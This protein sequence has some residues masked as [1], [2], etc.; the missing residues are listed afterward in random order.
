MLNLDAEVRDSNP[1]W[2]DPGRIE[3]D[4]HLQ[5]FERGAFQWDP[6]VMRALELGG[7]AI[8]TLRGPRQVGKTTTLKRVIAREL[9]RGRERV[10]FFSF[11]LVE[12]PG[13]VLEVLRSMRRQHPDPEGP[14]LIVLDE[15]TQVEGWA[16]GVKYAWDQGLIRED[17]LILSGSSARD[18][19]EGSELLPGR[20]GEDEDYVQL[21]VSFRSFT[22]LVRDLEIDVPVIDPTAIASEENRTH[23][24]RATLALEAL[25]DALADYLR[26]GG[27]PTPIDDRLREGEVSQRTLR[28][29]WQAVAGDLTKGGLKRETG[30]KL[31]ERV[32]LGL[33]S[34]FA[35]S[36][37]AGDMDVHIDTAKRYV[38][39]LTL[40]FTLL[41]LYFW[42]LS[43]A[44]FN[45]SKQ[46]KV[47]F[48]DPILARLPEAARSTQRSIDEAGLVEGVVAEAL[49]R[50]IP[51]SLLETLPLP[52]SI[53]YW[54][55]TSGREIDFLADPTRD[56]LPVEVKWSDSSTAISNAR[57]ALGATFDRGIVLTR[58]VAETDH[59]LP[60]IPVSVFLYLITDG[61]RLLG[62]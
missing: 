3:D 18:V 19:V 58:S 31:V 32:A 56:L 26:C 16:R 39:F 50:A 7:A 35:W 49:Y 4:P 37:A 60:A 28:T 2:R 13:T 25:N 48:R 43:S 55:A 44:R 22:G 20:R 62:V 51:M 38:R 47:Y 17:T 27:F 30:L 5:E 8:H 9:K 40:G 59:P 29:I 36:S 45:E 46:R 33:G 6:P 15:I 21:P 11:D 54:K 61:R 53:G 52:R 10:G 1:W 23:V 42:D 14:W 57:R 41:P 12:D 34:P 24:R